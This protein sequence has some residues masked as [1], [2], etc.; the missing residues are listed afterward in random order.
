MQVPPDGLELAEVQPHMR[1]PRFPPI[2]AWT[3]RKRLPTHVP[4]TIIR[5]AESMLELAPHSPATL[6]QASKSRR[7]P[8]PP[9]LGGTRSFP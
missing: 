5:V 7:F 9:M 8:R 2:E 4:W 3:T 1:E 6:R